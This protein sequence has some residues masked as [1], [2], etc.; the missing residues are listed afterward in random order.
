MCSQRR[1]RYYQSSLDRCVSN[2]ER[3]LFSHVADQ[4]HGSTPTFHSRP[5]VRVRSAHAGTSPA[6]DQRSSRASQGGTRAGLPSSG[7]VTWPS[8]A[9]SIGSTENNEQFRLSTRYVAPCRK[10]LSALRLSH[11]GSSI[12]TYSAGWLA[13]FVLSA[14]GI[15][16]EAALNVPKSQRAAIPMP[17]PS[18]LRILFPTREWVQGSVLGEAGGGSMFCRKSTWEAAKFP[19]NLFCESRSRRGRVLM[20]S[21]VGQ[22]VAASSALLLI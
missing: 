9:R 15:S 4:V 5:C 14:R 18:T 10:L 7:Q 19:R 1:A 17:T 22:R 12:G 20:H 2:L 6:F 21:K 3:S 11:Q 13:E 8:N 16:P